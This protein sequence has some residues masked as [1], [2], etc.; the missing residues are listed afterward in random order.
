MSDAR[1]QIA[2]AHDLSDGGFAVAISE[3]ALGAKVGA[4]VNIPEDHFVHLFSETPGRILVAIES[5]KIG[6]LIGRAIDLEITTT[7]IGKTGGDQLI[8][9]NLFSIS[10]AEMSEVNCATL[11]RLFG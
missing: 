4:T 5:E 3:M 11:P 7:R 1:D 8:F 9:E 6:E 10:I 2:A